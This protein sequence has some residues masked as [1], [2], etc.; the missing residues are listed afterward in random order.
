MVELETIDVAWH[1]VR[2][3]LCLAFLIVTTLVCPLGLATSA[4]AQQTDPHLLSP[5]DFV[6]ERVAGEP[7]I[8]FP[9]F[10]TFD[11]QRRLYVAESSG[12]DLYAELVAQTRKCRIS[13]LEDRDGNGSFEHS[14]VFADNLG[15]PMGLAWRDGRLYVADPPDLIVF[16][17]KDNDGRGDRREVI[18]TGFGHT[19]NGSLHGLTFGP[20]GWLYMTMGNPDSY[21]LRRSDGSVLAG[22]NGALFRVRADGSDPQVV[23]R[24]FTNL[25]EVTFLADGT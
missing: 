16:E 14:Q 10:A 11:D 23:C 6:I 13:R 19:D 2:R 17:D 15:F 20:D 4:N 1:S 5:P 12:L 3:R 25:V 21:R 22:T 18:L 24:G 9:M 8:R 7:Q